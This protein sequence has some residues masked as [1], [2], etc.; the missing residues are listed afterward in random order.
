MEVVIPESVSPQPPLSIGRTS[1]VDWGSF[2][3]TIIVFFPRAASLTRF[4]TA[5][6]MFSGEVSKNILCGVQP[7]SVRC[8]TPRSS[9]RRL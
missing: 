2:S 1:L 3:A 7:Q 9:K 4:P 6:M 5:V 8:G